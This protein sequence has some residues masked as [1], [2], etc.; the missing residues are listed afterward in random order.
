M[1]SHRMPWEDFLAQRQAVLDTWPTGRDVADIEDGLRYQR[2]LPADKS[3]AK[4]MSKA[5]AGGL[6][7]LQPR[8]G[9]ALIDDH[10]RL[11]RFLETEGAADLLPTTIDAY[12]RQNRYEEAARGIEK[13]RVAG[14]VAAQRLP[15]RQPR[16]RRL[17]Q[18]HRVRHASRSRSATARPTPG[19]SRRSRSPGAS[20][21]TKAAASP[22]TSPTPRR[23]TLGQC[24]R[25]WQYVDR[26]VGHYEEN[27]ISINREPFGP[28][29]GTLVP[30]FISHTI[31]ILEGL[32][33]LEQG[34][35]SLTLGY[36]QGGNV[37]QDLAAARL[38][39]G[40]GRHV[41]PGGGIHRLRPDHSSSI[42]GWA[43]FPRTKP[44]P[45]PSSAWA[46]TWPPPARSRRSSSSPRTRP[47]ASRRK[48]PTPPGSRRPAR[49]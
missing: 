20:P 44:R 22:T 8:A 36:G 4:A 7:L 27:G 39:P 46:R 18:G 47:W 24:L 43:A 34:V 31:A 25:D 21:A 23:S 5:K 6:T 1:R 42:S 45:S 19:C 26:L 32:L 16:P 49:S 30:P 11:L 17:P 14:H 3:F 29:T 33:A 35:R 9:V 40:A 37:L 13:S 2:S 12:T 28:L 38:A 41:L 48:R 10:I 15:G